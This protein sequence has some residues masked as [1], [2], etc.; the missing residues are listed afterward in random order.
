ME[1]SNTKKKTFIDTIWDFFASVKLA[2]VAFSFIALSSI[3]GTILEQQADP[4]K[5]L[6][7]LARIFGENSAPSIYSVLDSM[8]FMDMYH[9]WWFILFLMVFSANI[10]ICSLDRIPNVLKVIRQPLFP[11]PVDKFSAYPIKKELKLNGSPE[12]MK[13]AVRTVIKKIG[14]SVHEVSEGGTVQLYSQKSAYSRLG[15][16]ITHLSILVIFL[17]AVIGI[18]FGFNGFLNLPEGYSSDVAYSRRGSAPHELGF[19]IKLD[20]F[21]VDYYP[22]RE[23][24]RDYKSW[25]SV[26]KN[27]QIVK[28]QEIEVNL[29]LRFM[30]YTFYQSSYGVMP[31][32]QGMR[33]FIFRIVP[34]SGES[35]TIRVEPAGS[36]QIP[37]T[38]IVG[39]IADFNPALAFR[40]DG[41]TFTYSEMMTN[42]AV[43]IKFSEKGKDLYSGWILKRYPQ[44][45]NLP[46]G[47]RIEFI[48]YW[49]SQYTGLQVRKDPGVWVVY[50]GCFIMAIGLYNAFFMSHRKIWVAL[51]PEGKNSTKM[52]I[53]ATSHKNRPA[54]ESKINN[55]VALITKKE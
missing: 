37:G 17:G 10:V 41:S 46:D 52:L 38:S 31:N 44:T 12:K 5:N 40:E 24:P 22:E 49:G 6:R 11:L 55:A 30:G 48:D 39:R 21:D 16:Y 32:D 29:P 1:N 47:N 18:Y 26:V 25:L 2:V 3:I 20:D 14:F 53:A 36:F 42:P 4:S 8:G 23:M 27:G 51:V 43:F 50:L 45:W 54:F 33:E 15:V 35:Q 34:R 13:E 19:T 7:L 9:S 28:Q